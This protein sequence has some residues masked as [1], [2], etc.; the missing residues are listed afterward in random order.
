MKKISLLILLCC[1]ACNNDVD[2]P[3]EPVE[4]GQRIELSIPGT[5]EVSVYSTATVSECTI[6]TLWVCV[7]NGGKRFIEMIEGDRIMHNGQAT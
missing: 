4:A 2:I 1:V 7:F 3:E 6:D 5:Q